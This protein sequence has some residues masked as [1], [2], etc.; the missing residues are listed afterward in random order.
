MSHQAFH[1]R[2]LAYSVSG[3]TSLQRRYTHLLYYEFPTLSP[4][5]WI[6]IRVIVLVSTQQGDVMN[7]PFNERSLWPISLRPWWNT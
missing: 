4:R 7:W 1:R 5:Y 3:C 2:S 6:S